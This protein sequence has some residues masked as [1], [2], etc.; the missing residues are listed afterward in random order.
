[1]WR[2]G[3][4]KAYISST[5]ASLASILARLTRGGRAWATRSVGTRDAVAAAT[6]PGDPWIPE[7]QWLA[8]FP[9]DLGDRCGWLMW[10]GSGPAVAQSPSRW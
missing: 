2:L 3:P 4:E 9:A 1:L 6:H 5:M 8:G 7:D 10:R